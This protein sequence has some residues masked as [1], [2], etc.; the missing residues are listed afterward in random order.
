MQLVTTAAI[1]LLFDILTLLIGINYDSIGIGSIFWIK[2]F[3]WISPFL[4]DIL[5]LLIV[6]NS[7]SNGIG[8]IFWIKIFSYLA[9]SSRC[10]FTIWVLYTSFLQVKC[11]QSFE[12]S[13]QNIFP[14]L[15]Y[16]LL[17]GRGIRRVK[18]LS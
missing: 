8:S 12:N 14:I 2:Y 9:I 15:F 10:P 18:C 11:F 1:L 6:I 5:M 7:D 13:Q 4:F 16:F 17:K 3:S